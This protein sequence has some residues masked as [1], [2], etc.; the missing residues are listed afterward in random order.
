MN[1][2]QKA[3]KKAVGAARKLHR[4]FP[5][6]NGIREASFWGRPG[7]IHLGD[8]AEGGTIDE[9]PAATMYDEYGLYKLGYEFGIHPKLVKALSDLGFY[10]EF[11]DGGT[12][13]AY[14]G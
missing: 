7:A 2:E 4:M 12:V 6:I 5:G 10:A 14:Q 1:A 8:A 3:K 9:L 11:H 13:L